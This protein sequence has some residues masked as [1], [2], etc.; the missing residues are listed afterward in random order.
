MA[1]AARTKLAT[2]TEEAY[3]HGIFGVPTFVCEGEILFGNDRLDML[4]WRL[5]LKRTTATVV[6]SDPHIE[7]RSRSVR[8]YSPTSVITALDHRRARTEGLR[9]DTKYTKFDP[10]SIHPDENRFR[11]I[12]AARKIETP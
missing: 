8:Y 5:G 4:A 6:I 10:M 1:P 11:I 3:A 7:P 12:R 9:A 2:S